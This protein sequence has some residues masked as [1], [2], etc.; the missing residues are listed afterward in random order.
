MNNSIADYKNPIKSG[1]IA[2][3]RGVKRNE[4]PFICGK[5]A[6]H[7]IWWQQGWDKQSKIKCK[8]IQ[9]SAGDYSGC[10]QTDGDCPECGK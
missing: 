3:L 8:G 6:N 1:K 2:F 5:H 9:L 10:T 4:N 7:F